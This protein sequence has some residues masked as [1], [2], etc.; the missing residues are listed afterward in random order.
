MTVDDRYRYSTDRVAIVRAARENKMSDGQI[1][2]AVCRLRAESRFSSGEV[3]GDQSGWK[4]TIPQLLARV[5][6]GQRGKFRVAKQNLQ[7]KTVF[8]LLASRGWAVSFSQRR[9]QQ[10]S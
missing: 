5:G 3:F 9:H 10:K 2:E 7:P 1:L 8:R 6:N 4:A